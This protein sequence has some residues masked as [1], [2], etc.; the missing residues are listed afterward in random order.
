MT[1][2]IEFYMTVSKFC[3]CQSIFRIYVSIYEKYK[4]SDGN[5]T[6]F[7]LFKCIKISHKRFQLA[8]NLPIIISYVS[9]TF[10]LSKNTP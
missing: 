2:M 5:C 8:D 4:Y 7:H 10:G 6:P 1:V 9:K 3:L